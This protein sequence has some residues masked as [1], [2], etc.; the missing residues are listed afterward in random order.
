MRAGR[1]RE[2][3]KSLP[4]LL[5]ALCVYNKLAGGCVELVYEWNFSLYIY[6]GGDGAV[7]G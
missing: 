1:S 5:P 2:G 4:M 7:G 6:C 3:A